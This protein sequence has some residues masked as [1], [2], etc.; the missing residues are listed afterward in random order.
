MQNDQYPRAFSVGGFY[1]TGTYADPLL[2]AA[3]Q[4]RILAGGTPK[5]DSALSQVWVQAQQ[6]IYRPDASDRGLT[7]F[8]GANWATSGEPDVE[9]MFFA[10]AYYKGPFAQRPNDT[11]GFAV[12]LLNVNPRIDERLDSILV[13]SYRRPGE[14]DG[15][16]LRGVLRLRRRTRHD[17]QAVLRVHVPSRP[18]D[19]PAPSGNITH[20]VYFG[21]LFE[22]D[23]AHLFGLPSAEP[24]RRSFKGGMMSRPWRDSAPPSYG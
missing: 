10:G 23:M 6:M 8:G 1:V 18:G 14:R 9:R 4:N 24:I 21:V 11:L 3:G 15:D 12:S 13:Q 16:R 20:A 7:V 2:N 17:D 19:I 5:T 22:V